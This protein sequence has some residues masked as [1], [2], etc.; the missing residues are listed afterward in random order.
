[1]EFIMHFKSQGTQKVKLLYKCKWLPAWNILSFNNL[2]FIFLKQIFSQEKVLAILSI[3]EL[4]RIQRIIYHYHPLCK[5]LLNNEIHIIDLIQNKF[6]CYW[7][8]NVSVF[9][10]VFFILLHILNLKNSIVCINWF[11]I[12]TP[13]GFKYF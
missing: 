13:Y 8:L 2:Y 6:N 1:M 7:S 4:Q 11:T 3:Q 5:S 9:E 12:N 10:Q